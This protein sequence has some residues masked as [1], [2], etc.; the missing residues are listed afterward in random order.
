MPCGFDVERTSAEYRLT[1][2]PAGWNDVE[3]VRIGQ[4]FA[5]D[6]N[7]YFSRPGPRVVRGIEILQEILR[8][9]D[10]GACRGEGWAR[11]RK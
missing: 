2:F 7:A 4:V 5:V 1:E 10:S 6:A 8:V 9:C 3:A 11:L